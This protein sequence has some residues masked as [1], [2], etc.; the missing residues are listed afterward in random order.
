MK[1]FKFGQ[2]LSKEDI[3]DRKKEIGI[4]SKICRTSGRAVVYG[5][6]RFGKTSVVKNVVMVNY[7]KNREKSLA[8]Y[9]DLLQVDSME[10]AAGRLQ[11]AFEQA[12][13][14]RAKIKTFINNI[15]NYIKHFRV[16][17]S[18]DPLSGAPTISLTGAHTKDE[19]S[20]SQIFAG[21]K[22]FSEEYD[23]LLILDEFQDI[24]HVAGLEALL[25]S[26]IQNLNRS[27]VILLGSK[28]HIL[29]EIF[30]NESNPF[31]G[32]GTDVEFK[33]IPTSEWIPYMKERFQP[34]GLTIEEEGSLE[35]CKLMRNVPN[36]VQELCQ[37]ITL[38]GETGHLDTLRIHEDLANLIENKS[39]RY[40]EK[41][42]EF[43][44][45]E[46]KVLLALA[47][48]E[49]ISSIASTRF[50]QLAGVSAT[51]AKATVARFVEQGVLDHCETDY[52]M[53]D[54]IFR[55]FL[56]RKFGL[57]ASQRK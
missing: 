27:A 15:H 2:L 19:R 14:K 13:S 16:E 24:N 28:R 52:L 8:I 56:L 20:L 30:H 51:A 17:I 5:P 10:D 34:A 3:C 4:L 42:G 46:K 31:Y 43:S 40:M 45:K 38:S 6:R 32:F 26:E 37:W 18:V 23:T 25:R 47:Q 12:L 9:A 33:G 36:S 29:R 22:S 53:T 48:Q 7:L 11:G 44:A 41:L 54:P 57:T 55:L 49:P 50:V 39:G 1:T 35:I 21:I